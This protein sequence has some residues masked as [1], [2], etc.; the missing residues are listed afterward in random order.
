MTAPPPPRLTPEQ[1]RALAA[2]RYELRRFLAFSS[3]EAETAGLA[4][5]QYQA[6]LAIRARPDERPFT[7]GELA[8]QLLVRQHS[9][10]EL[11]NRMEKAGLVRRAPAP[12]D[13]R[14]VAVL[15]TPEGEAAIDSLA[16]TH[17]Q[18]LTQNEGLVGRLL[19]LLDKNHG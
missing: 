2:F 13:A 14:R 5:Q 4:P 1:Y 9:A 11:V 15:L 19:T 12:G 10:A 6:L 17:L 18:E 16:A 8:E 7:I 3:R